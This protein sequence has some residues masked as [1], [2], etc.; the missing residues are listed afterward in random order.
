MGL[1]RT[2]T[3][4]EYIVQCDT[5]NNSKDTGGK[6]SALKFRHP[7][8]QLRIQSYDGDHDVDRGVE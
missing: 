7:K 2:G 8:T 1:I 6:C 5:G 4:G 3:R